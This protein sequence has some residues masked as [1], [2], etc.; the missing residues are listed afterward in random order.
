[1]ADFYSFTHLLWRG[2]NDFTRFTIT[3]HSV[4]VSDCGVGGARGLFAYISWLRVGAAASAT[5]MGVVCVPTD[6]KMKCEITARCDD[7]AHFEE[8][9]LERSDDNR[10][11]FLSC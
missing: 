5:K 3:F 4:C 8:E 1:M 9:F 7:S 6:E 2:L 10:C 11:I